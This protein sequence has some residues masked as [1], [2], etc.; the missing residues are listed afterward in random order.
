EEYTVSVSDQAQDTSG[1]H[2]DAD[3]IPLGKYRF[4]FNTQTPSLTH[5]ADP[6][7]HLFKPPGGGINGNVRIDGSALKKTVSGRMDRYQSLYN[8]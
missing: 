8:A 4:S 1:I 7:C 6:G 5:Y 2:L 3:G